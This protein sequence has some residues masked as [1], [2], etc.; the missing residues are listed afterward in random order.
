MGH[1]GVVELGRGQDVPARVHDATQVGL[2]QA[3]GFHQL[4][5]HLG[6]AVVEHHVEG[7]L[8]HAEGV[9][10]VQQFGGAV[11]VEHDTLEGSHA[12]PFEGHVQVAAHLGQFAVH[13]G[14]HCLHFGLAA[15][16][17]HCLHFVGVDAADLGQV[18]GFEVEALALVFGATDTW[19]AAFAGR[20][21][22]DGVALH[23]D[24]GGRGGHAGLGEEAHVTQAGGHGGRL[25]DRSDHAG[26]AERVVVENV[27]GCH[28]WFSGNVFLT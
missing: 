9:I 6:G 17:A 10:Q 26:H 1:V 5:A 8:R 4:V 25:V 14:L 21:Q 24:P 28:F 23:F 12:L 15:E 22:V 20:H 7:L 18:H 13:D 3:L 2:A 11:G 27:E 16:G 19:L